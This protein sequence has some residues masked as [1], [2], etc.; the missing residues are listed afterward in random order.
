MKL[1]N[2]A[3]RY[4]VLWAKTQQTEIHILSDCEHCSF[5]SVL[6]NLFP[7]PVSSCLPNA[8]LLHIEN[9]HI[10]TIS[11]LSNVVLFLQLLH[12]STLQLTS[13]QLHCQQVVR[14]PTL[15]CTCPA[16]ERKTMAFSQTKI[17]KKK[18]IVKQ[19][20]LFNKQLNKNQVSAKRCVFV[21]CNITLWQALQ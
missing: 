4:V 19:F 3:S 20:L 21:F 14:P 10:Y 6:S 11:C 8:S 12:T 18:S 15:Q 16:S 7:P 5:V 2:P 13:C 9:E 1:L 17:R